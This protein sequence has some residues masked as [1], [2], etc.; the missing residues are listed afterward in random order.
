MIADRLPSAAVARR[1]GT[2]SPLRWSVARPSHFA[3][4]VI[5]AL[6]LAG[7]LG[8]SSAFWATK[9]EYPLGS[10][11][12]GA[13][14]TWP[15]AGSRD[16]DPYTRAINARTGDIPLAVGEGLILRAAGDDAGRALD[17]RCAY[18]IGTTMPQARYWT[19]TLYGDAGR[20][21]T[22]EGRSSFTSAEVLRDATGGFVITLSREARSGNWLMMPGSGRVSLVLRLYDTPAS[23]GSAALDRASVPAIERLECAS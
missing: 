22:G 3:G 6:L 14:T 17:T 8:L 16:A 7:G 1:R 5:Y 20:P 21:V 10:V 13:W 2:A 9:G 12:V 15:K 11:A 23:S 19:L 18:R 4:F